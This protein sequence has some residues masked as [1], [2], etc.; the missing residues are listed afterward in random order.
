MSDAVPGTRRKTFGAS[1][2]NALQMSMESAHIPLFNTASERRVRNTIMKSEPKLLTPKE[3]AKW[4]D[5]SVDWVHNHATRKNPRL[6]VV[7]IGKLLRFRNEDVEAFIRG[8]SGKNGKTLAANGSR[9]P[10]AR[11]EGVESY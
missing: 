6:P 11:W 7:R 1:T 3:V 9:T 10:E 4:L 5:V 2:P 8:Q